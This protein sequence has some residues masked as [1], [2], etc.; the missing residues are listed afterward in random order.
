MLS[1]VWN[2]KG[3]QAWAQMGLWSEVSLRPLPQ[4][5]VDKFGQIAD[6]SNPR[7]DQRKHCVR[8]EFGSKQPVLAAYSLLEVQKLIHMEQ[9][10]GCSC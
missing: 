5:G 4:I 6:W 7:L 2:G 1:T 10:T 9:V 3:N 8:Y